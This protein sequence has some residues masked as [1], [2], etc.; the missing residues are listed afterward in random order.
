MDG[1]YRDIDLYIAK[2]KELVGK[3]GWNCMDMGV[4]QKFQEGLIKWIAAQILNRDIWPE[5]L[6]KWIEAA[7][8][9]VRQAVIKQEHLGDQKNY[10][11]LVQQAKWQSALGLDKNPQKDRQNKGQKDNTPM[12]VDYVSTQNS[13]QGQRLQHLTPE[14]WKKLMD[15]GYCFHCRE[16]GH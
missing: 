1:E 13:N 7:W 15:E 11:L 8:W 14:E 5:T 9:E 16:K 12:E 3:V 4:L 6:D 10:G 2:F